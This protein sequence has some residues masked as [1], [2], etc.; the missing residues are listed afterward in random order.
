MPQNDHGGQRNKRGRPP[1]GKP[2]RIKLS[3]TLAPEVLA[4]VDAAAAEHGITRSEEIE[5]RLRALSMPRD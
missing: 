3:I 5:R 1:T 4:N 2:R